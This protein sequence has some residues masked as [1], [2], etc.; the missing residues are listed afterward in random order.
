MAAEVQAILGVA[1][2]SKK[3]QRVRWLIAGGLYT[4]P[5]VLDSI[6]HVLVDRHYERLVGDIEKCG[7]FR[8]DSCD[9]QAAGVHAQIVDDLMQ[10]PLGEG[11][12]Y[13][14]VVADVA[15]SSLRKLANL[16]FAGKAMTLRSR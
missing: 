12:R 11:D 2:D 14:E 3:I 10:Y 5:E 7:T 4:D 1:V 6:E 8:Q 16:I 15:V 13:H 9:V